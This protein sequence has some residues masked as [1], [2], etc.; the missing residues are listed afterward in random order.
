MTRALKCVGR[1]PQRLMFLRERT[2]G[3]GVRIPG[4]RRM[5][6]V[7]CLA[8]ILLGQSQ[9]SSAQEPIPARA[10]VNFVLAVHTPPGASL[11][12]AGI[13]Q[14]DYEMVVSLDA[15]DSRGL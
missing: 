12:D 2:T 14:G 9:V 8:A 4:S 1:I 7:T 11:K 3:G 13:L 15:L 5:A 6:V 10:G